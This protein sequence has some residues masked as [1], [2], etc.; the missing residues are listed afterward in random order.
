MAGS[1]RRFRDR[2]S[3]NDRRHDRRETGDRR[4]PVDDLP[5]RRTDVTRMEHENL[6]RQIDQLIRLLERVEIELH[7]QTQRIDQLDADFR[8]MV[9]ERPV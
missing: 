5:S 3:T 8:G 9:R 7:Q 6:C 4:H 2:R 1:E